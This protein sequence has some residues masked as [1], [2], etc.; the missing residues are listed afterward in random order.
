MAKRV[1]LKLAETVQDHRTGQV[2]PP[3]CFGARRNVT[4]LRLL[5]H[6]HHFSPY[7]GAIHRA[8]RPPQ[9]AGTG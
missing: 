4:G 5:S 2:L 6:N 1:Y 9:A 8:R 3:A 7:D